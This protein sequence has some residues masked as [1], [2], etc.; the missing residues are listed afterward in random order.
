MSRLIAILNNDPV[1]MKCC[2]FAMRDAVREAA[3]EG[4]RKHDGWGLGFYQNG[5]VLLQK[6]PQWGNRE[7][8]YFDIAK[9]LKT[10]AIVG[11]VRK[12]TVGACSPKSRNSFPTRG[13][14]TARFVPAA[15]ILAKPASLRVRM[16]SCIRGVFSAPA[17]SVG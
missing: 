10:D 15:S 12:A 3:P 5:E 6:K 14:M 1:R 4:S 11:H 7:V 17:G 8:D 16:N 2:L 9:D 13:M